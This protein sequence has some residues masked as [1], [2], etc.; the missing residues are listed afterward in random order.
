MKTFLRRFLKILGALALL[1]ALFHLVENWRGRRAWNAWVAQ[2]EALGERL[3]LDS[4]VPP[5]VPEA[6]NFAAVPWVA[7]AV[8][9]RT[10]GRLKYASGYGDDVKYCGNWAA[11]RK[12][13]LD[14]WE[15]QL[16]KKMDAVLAPYE[17]ELEALT[18]A[19]QRP[20]NRFLLDYRDW[21]GI[22][23]LLGFRQ[24][25]RVLRT[26][27]LLNL[28]KGQAEA[29]LEDVLTGFRVVQHFQF[30]PHLI[31]QLL[32][33]AA[34]NITMQTV[35]EATQDHRWNEAQL[36]RLQEALGKVDLV[37]SMKRAWQFERARTATMQAMRSSQA[38]KQFMGTEALGASL[39]PWFVDLLFPRGWVTQNLLR[40]DRSTAQRAVDEL[41]PRQHRVHPLPKPL[42]GPQTR[43]G[44]YTFMADT[45]MT[46]WV[47]NIRMA[48][49][50]SGLDQAVVAC[51]L[52]RYR[53]AKKDYPESL[54]ALVPTY[55]PKV[56]HDVVE[57]RPLRYARQSKDSYRLYALGWDGVDGG[58]VFPTPTGNVT[59]PAKGDWVWSARR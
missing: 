11:G 58:G 42:P 50:Q 15:V 8:A 30:E 49:S 27:A 35:W 6:E 13:D 41:D 51:A 33:I 44:P 53:L 40:M 22:P 43:R 9:G 55:L 21:E 45:T 31:S 4:L 46:I 48:R 20:R 56:P 47:Q 12:S 3:D 24:E 17:P 32:R 28:R 54:E 14:G 26:R 39:K 57:G 2:R 18:E 59:D 1:L 7:A 10:D 16:G 25:A 23:A 37:D 29:A 36:L 5:P 52:E 38:M 34:T 19:A